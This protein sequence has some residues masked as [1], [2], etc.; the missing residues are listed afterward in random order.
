ML[1]SGMVYRPGLA[2][3]QVHVEPSMGPR[4]DSACIF[5]SQAMETLGGGYYLSMGPCAMC[6]AYAQ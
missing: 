1:T 2:R 4:I 3:R 5:L 6:P